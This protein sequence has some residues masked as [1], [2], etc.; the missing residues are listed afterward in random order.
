MFSCDSHDCLRMHLE[1]VSVE[2]LRGPEIEKA[3]EEA[4]KG[5]QTAMLAVWLSRL[6]NRAAARRGRCLL[7]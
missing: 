4:F 6:L 7:D 1:L 5:G 2:N 3:S